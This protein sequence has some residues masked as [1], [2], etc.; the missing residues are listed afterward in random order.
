MGARSKFPYTGLILGWL[1]G[2]AL[3][4]FGYLMLNSPQCPE[5]VTQAQI[6]AEG[7]IVGANVGLGLFKVLLVAGATGGILVTTRTI[8]R[9]RGAKQ[10]KP[11]EKDKD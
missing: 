3:A 6:D 11:H 5:G 4:V 2:I 8:F 9:S 7:C 1:A 10:E